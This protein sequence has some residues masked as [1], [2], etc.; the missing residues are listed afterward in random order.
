MNL[1]ELGAGPFAKHLVGPCPVVWKGHP[2]PSEETLA[3]LRRDRA[4]QH[5]DRA[6]PGKEHYPPPRPVPPTPLPV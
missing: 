3:Q 6:R 5:T 1:P 2:L 4:Q